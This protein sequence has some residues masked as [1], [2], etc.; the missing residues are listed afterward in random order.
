MFWAFMTYM[1]CWHKVVKKHLNPILIFFANIFFWHK[2]VLEIILNKEWAR[3]LALKGFPKCYSVGKFNSHFFLFFNLLFWK[4]SYLRKG[5][6]IVQWT[7][8]T[9]VTYLTVTKNTCHDYFS[10][11]SQHTYN[12][13]AL[14][15]LLFVWIF[16]K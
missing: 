2:F 11:I 9:P 6:R 5:E 4:M 1:G 7:P 14:F 8:I 16:W 12:I 3:K 15:F 13:C 10:C